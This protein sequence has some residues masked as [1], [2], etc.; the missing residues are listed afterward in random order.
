MSAELTTQ[1]FNSFYDLDVPINASEYDIVYSFFKN[2][3]S[4]ETLAQTFTSNLF[5]ISSLTNEKA[6]DLLKSF[7]DGDKLKIS[8][9][10]S[11]YLNTLNDNK[12]IMFG[13]NNV[14]SPNDKVQRNVIL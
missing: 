14:L 9:T 7:E 1:I 6:T 3:L 5:K 8:L 12:T 13:I 4:N 2:K 10:M 11:Y